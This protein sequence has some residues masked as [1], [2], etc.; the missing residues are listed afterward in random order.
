L[1]FLYPGDVGARL[2][3][4]YQS[5]LNL[6]WLGQFV[7]GSL[8]AFVTLQ[9]WKVRLKPA[10][11]KKKAGSER[12]RSATTGAKK[13]R[14]KGSTRKGGAVPEGRTTPVDHVPQPGTSRAHSRPAAS[15]LR[16]IPSLAERLHWEKRWSSLN[17]KLHEWWQHG[18]AEPSNAAPRLSQRPLVRLPHR[19]RPI[20]APP[21]Q[22]DSPVR[23]VGEEE[24]RCPYC[25]ELV[26]KN[27]PRGIT[28]CPICHTQHHADCWALTGVCQVPHYHE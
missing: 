15:P 23:L 10:G 17:Q 3:D 12:K 28:V 1:G 9:A 11:R 24:H 27:D 14:S 22:P 20:T 5:E 19:R 7:L 21:P 6:A 4:R 26:Q 16:D 25:L 2:P 13:P 18:L 8:L